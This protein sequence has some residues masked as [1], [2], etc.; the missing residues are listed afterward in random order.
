MVYIYL[1][2][3]ALPTFIYGLILYCLDSSFKIVSNMI[4]YL[5]FKKLQ[6]IQKKKK[7]TKKH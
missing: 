4:F 3:R 6:G 2:N 5:I 1:L 7:K